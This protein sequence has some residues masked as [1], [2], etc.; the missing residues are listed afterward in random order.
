MKKFVVKKIGEC[1]D[2]L[3]DPA[4]VSRRGRVLEDF[5]L[6]D[7][8]YR[9]AIVRDKVRNI[10]YDV[11]EE[12]LQSNEVMVPFS[13]EITEVI[14]ATHAVLYNKFNYR[15]SQNDYA[16]LIGMKKH[17]L[18][19]QNLR[20]FEYVCVL[21]LF[22]QLDNLRD[23]DL[24]KEEIGGFVQLL[25][26]SVL[27]DLDESEVDEMPQVEVGDNLVEHETDSAVNISQILLTNLE[28]YSDV[29]P[30]NLVELWR[31][32]ILILLPDLINF[33]DEYYLNQPDVLSELIKGSGFYSDLEYFA[34]AVYDF[35]DNEDADYLQN[36][37]GLII[38]LRNVVNEH[39]PAVNI[40]LSELVFSFL[41]E[42]V[43]VD[44]LDCED[45][46]CTEEEGYYIPN[47]KA[48]IRFHR[49]L[50]LAA[51][52]VEL[53]SSRKKFENYVDPEGEFEGVYSIL[54]NDRREYHLQNTLQRL[55]EGGMP[56]H[57]IETACNRLN[58]EFRRC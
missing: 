15:F 45:E 5:Y 52:L 32:F 2:S 36:L 31:E 57:R 13:D 33:E 6:G 48:P 22:D 14:N 43:I 20:L 29:F 58:I 25:T 30:D 54:K 50:L 1:T 26:L 4:V 9:I 44:R 46:E 34:N 38:N 18:R 53:E 41:P 28:T 21:N 55:S 37:H 11:I 10:F 47:T 3:V 7:F 8:T 35:L 23:A 17:R 56:I 12:L 19:V 49:Q 24:S 16:D 39:Y 51:G 42:I 27:F 40:V